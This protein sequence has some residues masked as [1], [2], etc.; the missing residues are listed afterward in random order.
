MQCPYCNAE[1]PYECDLTLSDGKSTVIDCE[2]C[3]KPYR[4]TCAVSV[5]Y[6]TEK[7]EAKQE[8]ESVK[9]GG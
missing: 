9:G 7:I 3:G 2:G 6:E 5:D 1:G 8:G 4:V